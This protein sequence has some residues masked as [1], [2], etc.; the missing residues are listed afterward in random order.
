MVIHDIIFNDKEDVMI[1]NFDGGISFVYD[2]YINTVVML[3]P[4]MGKYSK[5]G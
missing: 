3:V 1:D 4:M 5:N 2:G